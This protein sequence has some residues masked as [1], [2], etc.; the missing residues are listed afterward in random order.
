MNL[1]VFCAEKLEAK[2]FSVDYRLSPESK[3]PAPLEDCEK[4]FEWVINNS[5]GFGC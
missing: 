3:F 5:K 1:L 4:A 2:V